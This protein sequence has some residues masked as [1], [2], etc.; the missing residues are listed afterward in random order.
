[1]KHDVKCCMM[2]MWIPSPPN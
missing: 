1:M 2:P